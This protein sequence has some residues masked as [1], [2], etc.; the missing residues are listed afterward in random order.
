M[1]HYF[2]FFP[3]LLYGNTAVTNIIAKVQFDKSVTENLATFYPY[4]IREG[5]RADQIAQHYYDDPRYDWVIYLSNN[6]TDPY[7]EWPM[8]E[9]TLSGFIKEKYGSVANAAIQTMFYRVN[10]EFDETLLTT[11]QYAA[12]V[13][14]QKQYWAPITGYQD[15]VVSYQRKPIDLIAETN[16]VQALVGTFGEFTPGDTIKQSASIK[17]TVAT[18]NAT[19]LTIKNITGTWANATPVY[20]AVSNQQANATI[21]SVD[22]IYQPISDVENVYWSAVSAYDYEAE[23]N[24]SRKHIQVL[25]RVY[26]DAI[27]SDMRK[28]LQT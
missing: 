24:E 5:E 19:Q 16:K 6:I 13:G 14:P 3:T 11:A 10:H 20:Y 22:T 18:A 8:S 27:E 23:L 17:A 25:N 28:L 7:Y 2:S 12:L 9:S 21:V 1:S 26:I 4:T 15:Q